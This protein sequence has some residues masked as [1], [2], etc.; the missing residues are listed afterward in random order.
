MRYANGELYVGG[1]KKG[2][3]DG[4]GTYTSSSGWI[5]RYEGEWKNDKKN[6]KVPNNNT[7]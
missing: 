6:G 5:T 7:H 2:L 3:R 1:W 4:I